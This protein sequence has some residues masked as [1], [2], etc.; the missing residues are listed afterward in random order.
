MN[1]T[2]VDEPPDAPT[3]LSVS[4]NDDNPSTALDVSWTAPDADG[5]PPITGYDIQYRKHSEIDWTNHNFDPVGT[6]TMTTVPNLDSNTTYQVQ[7]RATNDEGKGQWATS[8]GT[9]EK[10]NLT[11]AFISA[12]YTL[13]EG[14]TATSTVTVTPTA[15]RDVTVTITMT[16][17]GATLSGLTNEMLTIERGENSDSFTI[18]A[19]QDNGRHRRRGGPYP[20]STEG[21][22]R[23]SVLKRQEGAPVNLG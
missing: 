2:D 7:V 9:T 15:D 19:D 12:T 14:D 13:N 3:D 1:V 18:S 11:V 21:G 5:I 22:R 16:G 6:T 10:A 23:V 4:T 17:A 20:E 8:S